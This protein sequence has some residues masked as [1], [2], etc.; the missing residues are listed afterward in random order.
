MR[1][2]LACVHVSA[3][4]ATRWSSPAPAARR[5]GSGWVVVARQAVIV[6]IL[7]LTAELPRAHTDAAHE[8]T[9]PLAFLKT[10]KVSK[11]APSMLRNHH[12]QRTQSSSCSRPRFTARI[13]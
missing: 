6:A 13:R 10:H 2:L 7:M 8:K 1:Q 3:G 9:T 11:L 12:A 4:S 5:T